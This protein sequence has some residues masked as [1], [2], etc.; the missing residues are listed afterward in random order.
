MNISS[1]RSG[2]SI[3]AL[4]LAPTD[5]FNAYRSEFQYDVAEAW[6][7]VHASLLALGKLSRMTPMRFAFIPLISLALLLQAVSAFGQDP[8]SPSEARAIAKEAY[9]YG[10]PL[11]ENYRFMYSR[12]MDGGG[13][14]SIQRQP[15]LYTP[16]DDVKMP[17]SDT[18]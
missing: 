9:I 11:V 10:F 12:F 18:L 15:R 3:R 4:D 6:N 1:R 17:T 16:D 5:S 13:F 7:G 8:V 2:L 14:N